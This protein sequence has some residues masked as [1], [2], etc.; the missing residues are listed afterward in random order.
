[1]LTQYIT[2]VPHKTAVEESAYS[3]E[4]TVLRST[5]NDYQHLLNP[6]AQIVWRCIDGVTDVSGIVENLQGLFPASIDSIQKDVTDLLATLVLDGL[7]ELASSARYRPNRASEKPPGVLFLA[8]HGAAIKEA[9]ILYR[10]AGVPLWLAGPLLRDILPYALQPEQVDIYKDGDINIAYT[11]AEIRTLITE[12]VIGVVVFVIPELANLIRAVLGNVPLVLRHSTGD[13]FRLKQAAPYSLFSPSANMLGEV[14][15]PNQWQSVKCV[16]FEQGD[17]LQEATELPVSDRSGIFTFINHYQ[18]RCSDSYAVYQAL[19]SSIPDIDLKHYGEGSDLGTRSAFDALKGARATLHIKDDGVCC[20]AVIESISVGVPVVMD[21]VSYR[22][23]GLEKYVV[24]HVSGMLFDTVEE[25]AAI[26]RKLS[27]DDEYLEQLRETTLQHARKCYQLDSGS[28]DEFRRFLNRALDGRILEASN[29]ECLAVS[30]K[31]SG[32]RFDIHP[33]ERI[34]FL[35]PLGEKPEVH[36]SS[37]QFNDGS[38][39]S[40]LQAAVKLK[41]YGYACELTDSV[42]ASG[43]YLVHPDFLHWE[44]FKNVN[45][46]VVSVR[47]DRPAQSDAHCEVVH[48]P[49]VGELNPEGQ[50]FFIPNYSQKNIVPRNHGQRGSIIENIVYSGRIHNLAPEFLAPEFGDWLHSH[51]MKLDIRTD[52][53]TWTDYSDVDVI[54]AARDFHSNWINKPANKLVNAWW[55]EVPAILGPECAFQWYRKSELDYF[56]AHGMDD[57][58]A[59]LLKL[60]EQ[61]ELYQKMISNAQRRQ[62]DV[63]DEFVT[64]EWVHT[65]EENIKPLVREW[66]AKRA[67]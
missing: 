13:K 22:A 66:F 51:G 46:F 54:V 32:G 17:L 43:V 20:N 33:S 40:V 8:N 18:P 57:V 64:K 41:Q 56:E 11:A 19:K 28:I 7:I 45:A 65:L 42:N 38:A 31:R 21:R 59:S 35:H 60:K 12:G 24:D 55:G 14:N 3:G 50:L 2:D 52:P 48:N 34:F 15:A 58:K 61:P 27:E 4:A 29:P 26:L 47:N 36:D 39:T 6:S 44:A 16:D 49:V 53:E 63:S 10:A 67:S 62:Q 1:M 37:F 30:K 23:L 5:F 25:G 9:S